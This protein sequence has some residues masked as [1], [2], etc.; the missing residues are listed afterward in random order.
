MS[1]LVL[2]LRV[3]VA[4]IFGSPEVCVSTIFGYPG[5]QWAGGN[6]LLLKRPVNSRDLGIAHRTLPLGSEVL[7]YSQRTHRVSWAVVIDRGPYG[8][9]YD[10]RWRLKKRRSDPGVWR[11]C[12]D[13]TPR[14]ARRLGHDGW[15]RIAVYQLW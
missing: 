7:V 2:I 3:A 9:M 14:V 8:A 13:L 4:L 15:D 1:E 5:D 12:A 6:A 11:G 10:G